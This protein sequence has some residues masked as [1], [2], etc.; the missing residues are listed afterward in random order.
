MVIGE[1]IGTVVAT[2]KHE[3]LVGYKILVVQVMTP[4]GVP[5]ETRQLVAV[6]TVGA[7]KG[8]LVILTAGSNASRA[9]GNDQVPVDA[10]IIGII[11]EIDLN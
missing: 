6:D 7:G 2:S 9:C 4:E 1:V 8:E 10:A 11:D 5:I 3:L